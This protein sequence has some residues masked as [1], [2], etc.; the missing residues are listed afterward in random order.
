MKKWLIFGFCLI[1][2]SP[3]YAEDIYREGSGLTPLQIERLKVCRELLQ[4]VDNKPLQTRIRELEKAP[5]PEEN[6]QILEAVARTY[7]EIVREQKVEGQKNKEWLHS[8]ITLNMAY[9]QLGG[10]HASDGNQD[11]LNRLIRHKLKEYLSS[12]LLN[13][14]EIFTSV[15]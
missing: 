12:A 3:V 7:D 5:Y 6:L 14:P 9:F 1:L 15:N 13:R 11:P 2:F 10:L 4:E 8:M